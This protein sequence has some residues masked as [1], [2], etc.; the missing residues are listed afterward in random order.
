MQLASAH[1]AR[2][3]VADR[4]DEL[5]RVPLVTFD[6]RP[7]SG[8]QPKPPLQ[9]TSSAFPT[10]TAETIADSR[11]LDWDGFWAKHPA[12]AARLVAT[13]AA[14]YED[15]VRAARAIALTTRP[16]MAD[17][18][19]QAQAVLQLADGSFHVTSLGGIDEAAQGAFIT[20][21]GTYPGYW[22]PTLTSLV[23]ELVAVV[24]GATMV[25]LRGKFGVPVKS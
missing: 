2:P 13:G 7:I 4:L 1:Q 21:L 24:G 11:E 5:G 17:G 20:R 23:P 12:G 10:W 25:D 22:R 18:D 14:S 3:A 15:A 8:N 6:Y 19:K 9:R 16:G